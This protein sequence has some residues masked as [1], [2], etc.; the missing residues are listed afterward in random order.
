MP[1][2]RANPCKPLFLWTP[3]RAPLSTSWANHPLCC[4]VCWVSAGSL[5]FSAHKGTRIPRPL[6]RPHAD[7]SHDQ[8]L[9]LSTSRSPRAAHSLWVSHLCHS[10]VPIPGVLQT[11][12]DYGTGLYLPAGAQKA[13]PSPGK[14]M[15]E[16]QGLGAG[17]KGEGAPLE[18]RKQ[19]GF[20]TASNTPLNFRHAPVVKRAQEERALTPPGTRAAFLSQALLPGTQQDCS[21][22]CRTLAQCS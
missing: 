17:S 21:N 5:A 3:H 1:V 6:C 15:R 22:T 7:S 10:S 13:Q 2:S 4:E 20:F 11:Q 14:A 19:Q 12:H 16:P 18:P 9:P 8:D